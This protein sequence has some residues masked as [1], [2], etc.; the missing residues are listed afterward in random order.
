MASDGPWITSI[1][2]YDAHY[3]R[4]PSVQPTAGQELNK[5]IVALLRDQPAG[6]SRAEITEA[7]GSNRHA[8]GGAIQKLQRRGL[9]V[10]VSKG[11]WACA[12]ESASASS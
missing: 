7:V 12:P 4:H 11:R 3:P 9:V 8:V 5:E 1:L 6:L 10:Q 2:V